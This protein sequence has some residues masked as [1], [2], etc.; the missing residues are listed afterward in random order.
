MVGLRHG[1]P[2]RAALLLLA[3]ISGVAWTVPGPGLAQSPPVAPPASSTQP[4]AL[5]EAPLTQPQLEQL[6]AMV[7]LF[8]DE[9]LTQILMAATYPLEIIQAQRWLARGGNAALRGDALATALEAQPWDPSV[10]SLVPFPDLIKMMVEHLEWTQA[11]GDAV[12]DQQEDVLNAI[13]VLR[14]RAQAAGFLKSGEQ[15]VV[16]VEAAPPPPPADG[17]TRIV[18]PPPQIITIAPA[19]PDIIFVPAYNPMIVFGRWPHVAYP[20]IFFPPPPGW[21]VANAILTGMAFA[22]G[23]AAVNSLWGWGRPGWGRG[24]IDVNVTRFNTINVNRSQISSN[25]WQHDVRHRGGAPYRSRATQER[26]RPPASG[27]DRSQAR[28]AL[29]GRVGQG[30]GLGGATGGG[31]RP[32]LSAVRQGAGQ[33]VN[34]GSGANRQQAANRLA[35]R[36]GQADRTT[37]S[38]SGRPSLPQRPEARPPALQGVGQGRDV[39]AA[40]QRG[41]ASRQAS[42]VDRAAV[43]QRASQARQGSGADRAAIQQRA[44]QARQNPGNRAAVQQRASQARQGGG[45]AGAGRARDA[46][47]ARRAGRN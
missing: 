14:A 27:V 33:R 35:D 29:R 38:A 44:S 46:A 28:D 40:A 12:L 4:A 19:R 45:G 34:Q 24:S 37:H 30:G 10:K 23:V 5:D 39:R 6:V 26:L 31:G 3:A 13:Q 17:V 42:G 47:A 21:G 8:P 41:A 25:R 32:D 15:Q 11:L 22:G 1:R 9:L 20:P 16:T 43:Q 36:R 2:T 7:A 18:V